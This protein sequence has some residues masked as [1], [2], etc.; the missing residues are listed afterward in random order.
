MKTIFCFELNY[1][2]LSLTSYIIRK[3]TRIH[4]SHANQLIDI[5]SPVVL[6]FQAEESSLVNHSAQRQ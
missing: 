1:L 5:Y 2:R 4:F 3:K 6:F